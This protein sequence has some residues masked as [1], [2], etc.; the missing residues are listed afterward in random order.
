M[1]INPPEFAKML[2]AEI[3][4]EVSDVGGGPFGMARLAHLMQERLIPSR[5][6]RPGRSTNPSWVTRS[7]VPMSET[8]LQRLTEL[9]EAMCTAAR[10]VS[11][12]QGAAQL[13]E[14]ALGRVEVMT[15][16][17]VEQIAAVAGDRASGTGAKALPW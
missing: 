4:G 11:P 8:T 14:E 15:A 12:M 1:P 16:S 9:A 6:E 3:V 5:G 2:G 10:K 13:L 7:K 17:A